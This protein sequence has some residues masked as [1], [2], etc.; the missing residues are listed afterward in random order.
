MS[1]ALIKID[2]ESLAITIARDCQDAKCMA[3]VAAQDVETVTSPDEQAKAVSVQT[4]L[5]ELR[6]LVEEER[7]RE[8][9]PFIAFGR[10]L[11]QTVK[12]FLA[13]VIAEED[14]IGILNGNYQ[15]LLIAKQKAAEMARLK[16]LDENNRLCQERLAQAKNLDEHQAIKEEHAQAA[17]QMAPL[18]VRAVAK[19]QVVKADIE[20]E[21]VD[22]RL[23]YLSFPNLVD[24]KPRHREIK[25]ALQNGVKLPGVNWREVVKSQTRGKAQQVLEV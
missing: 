10:T 20:L 25:E 7:Q 13:A 2:R 9:A 21:V 5:S 6:R 4:Q 16:E 15:Q 17:A 19:G 8:K 18:P 22:P 11:D 24:L 1:T 14:R 23:L 3:L 12:D